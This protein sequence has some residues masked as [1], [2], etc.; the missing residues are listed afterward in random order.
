MVLVVAL[1]RCVL[2]AR[3]PVAHGRAASVLYRRAGPESGPSLI[4]AQARRQ[5][6]IHGGEEAVRLGNVRRCDRPALLMWR[7][8]RRTDQSGWFTGLGASPLKTI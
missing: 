8:Q 5:P 6:P 4:L 3:L 7:R 1:A 2:V